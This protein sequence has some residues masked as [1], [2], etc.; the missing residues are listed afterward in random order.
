MQDREGTGRTG[1]TP[2]AYERIKRLERAVAQLARKHGYPAGGD[3]AAIVSE[4]DRG[5]LAAVEMEAER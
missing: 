2:T 5:E 3:L 1:G 4:D